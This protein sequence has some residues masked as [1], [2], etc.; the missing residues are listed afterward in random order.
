MFLQVQV[1]TSGMVKEYEA[2]SLARIALKDMRFRSRRWINGIATSGAILG[3][4]PLSAVSAHGRREGVASRCC[5]RADGSEL[6]G[7]G[8]HPNRNACVEQGSAVQ[9]RCRVLAFK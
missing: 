7:Q 8:I 3:E 5:R 4:V 9:P 6:Q 1:P 2:I